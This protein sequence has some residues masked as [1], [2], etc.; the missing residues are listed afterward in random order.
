MYFHKPLQRRHSSARLDPSRSSSPL[1][2]LLTISRATPLDLLP[3]MIPHKRSQPAT[4]QMRSA[5]PLACSLSPKNSELSQDTQPFLRLV[6]PRSSLESGLLGERLGT[7]IAVRRNPGPDV[8]T[9]VV[10]VRK[11]TR[12]KSCNER[13]KKGLSWLEMPWGLDKL[14]VNR[15]KA[16]FKSKKYLKSQSSELTVKAKCVWKRGKYPTMQK[17]WRNV[18]PMRFHSQ[19][20]QFSVSSFDKIDQSTEC[21][22]DSLA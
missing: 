17:P 14:P 10:K 13:L 15:K 6:R 4:P 12:G 5:Q 7:K 3:F 11:P 9:V 20:D 8:T 1:P 19:I 2:S 22:L 18:S 16:R 21:R